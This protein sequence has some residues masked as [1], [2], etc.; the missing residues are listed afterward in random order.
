MELLHEK[1]VSNRLFNT[2]RIDVYRNF[3]LEINE[4][5][6]VTLSMKN[7]KRKKEKNGINN[8]REREREREREGRESTAC[9][10]SSNKKINSIGRFRCTIVTNMHVKCM[11]RFDSA[12]SRS[13]GYDNHSYNISIQCK[14]NL[15]LSLSSRCAPHRHNRCSR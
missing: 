10:I 8:T 7:G 1:I 3:S 6:H 11:S 14:R 13:I 15:D 12:S 9:R 2:T 4:L 5:A